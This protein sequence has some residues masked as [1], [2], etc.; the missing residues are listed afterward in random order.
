MQRLTLLLLICAFAPVLLSSTSQDL[1]GPVSSKRFVPKVKPG[2]TLRYQVSKEVSTGM[3]DGTGQDVSQAYQIQVEFGT[4]SDSSI[5]VN[6]SYADMDDLFEKDIL[7]GLVGHF[8]LNL[9]TQEI[10]LEN[11]SAVSDHVLANMLRVAEEQGRSEEEMAKVERFEEMLQRP[12]LA[13]LL[14]KGLNEV[15]LPYSSSYS[16]AQVDTLIKKD[17][18]GQQIA[19][20]LQN[21][22]VR[23]K[24]AFHVVQ[25]SDLIPEG[26]LS[27]STSIPLTDQVAKA[28]EQQE[29][30]PDSYSHV[31][32]RFD[33]CKRTLTEYVK[34]EYQSQLGMVLSSKL[35]VTLLD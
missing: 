18:I 31:D 11:L 30:K 13:I 14:F 15:L 8:S 26:D 27:N 17:Y 5:H 9:G 10:V 4:V 32:I 23:E 34:H 22:V 35:S 19:Y 2:T 28:V 6:V 25:H 7:E 29:A 16:I 33:K 24:K 12:E 3:Q 21:A 20:L 1:R